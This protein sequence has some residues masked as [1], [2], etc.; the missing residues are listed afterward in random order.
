MSQKKTHVKL[1]TS[2]LGEEGR[3]W[4]VSFTDSHSLGS[5]SN[6]DMLEVVQVVAEK[7]V[8]K[9]VRNVT[10]FSLNIASSLAFSSTHTNIFFRQPEFD[11]LQLHAG[12]VPDPTTNAR[13]VPIY[14]STSFVFNDSAVIIHLFLPQIRLRLTIDLKHAAD[15]F[16]LR[17]ITTSH[18]AS[19]PLNV[20]QGSW[21]YIL[22][23]RQ[24]YRCMFHLS[25]WPI[26]IRV[27]WISLKMG[28][29]EHHSISG[30]GVNSITHLRC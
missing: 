25:V 18:F 6:S 14:A 9:R 11:T 1:K 4:K 5:C 13:A 10:H 23:H 16:G 17:C 3:D 29:T 22:A 28:R 30:D 24:S 21:S 2:K 15:L 27:W 12:Q 20:F 19:H 26:M 7:N 8:S